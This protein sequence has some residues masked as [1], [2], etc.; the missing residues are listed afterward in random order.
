MPKIARS[1]LLLVAL[2]GLAAY[3]GTVS[4]RADEC[5]C[6]LLGPSWRCTGVCDCPC[7]PAPCTCGCS[8]CTKIE[9]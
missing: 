2:L 9:G 6:E 8:S 4:A 3:P 7:S 5:G 1:L